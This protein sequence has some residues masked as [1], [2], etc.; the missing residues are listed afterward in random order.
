M[1]DVPPES[2]QVVALVLPTIERF[3]EQYLLSPEVLLH[4]FY[5]LEYLTAAYV[6]VEVVLK[7]LY[8]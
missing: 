1:I 4:I 3:C 7:S 6:F 5:C 8:G 2:V